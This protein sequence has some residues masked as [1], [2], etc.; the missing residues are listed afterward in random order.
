MG[1]AAAAGADGV[2][3]LSETASTLQDSNVVALGGEIFCGTSAAE[4]AGKFVE[5]ALGFGQKVPFVGPLFG[6]LTDLKELVDKD[7]EAG[8]EGVRLSLWCIGVLE[9][10]NKCK[11]LMGTK[12]KNGVQL[13]RAE[14]GVKALVEV[15]KGRE[16]ARSDMQNG[17]K[18]FFRG[19]K[20]FFTSDV[21]LSKARDAQRTV[22]EF[23]ETVLAEVT[24]D[25][26]AGVRDVRRDVGDLLKR[27]EKLLE[28]QRSL[29]DVKRTLDTIQTD[30]TAALHI[31]LNTDEVRWFTELLLQG[32]PV[33]FGRGLANQREKMLSLAGLMVT[34]YDREPE[35]KAQGNIRVRDVG[36]DAFR[37]GLCRNSRCIIWSSQGCCWVPDKNWSISDT[38][39]TFERLMQDKKLHVEVVVVCHKYG[40]EDTA[41]RLLAAGVPAVVWVNRSLMQ[42]STSAAHKLVFN[43]LH[44]TIQVI[45]DRRTNKA[46]AEGTLKDKM[47]GQWSR[48]KQGVLLSR[49]LPEVLEGEPGGVFNVTGFTAASNLTTT[50]PQREELE[51]AVCDLVCP[52]DL[53]ARIEK[54]EW[55]G[56]DRF[57]Y[58]RAEGAGSHSVN[59]CRAVAFEAC[60]TC[61]VNKE[62]EIC[63]RVQG[64]ADRQALDFHLKDRGETGNNLIWIDLMVD[65]DTA[66]LAAW[67]NTVVSS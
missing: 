19:A 30:V 22:K 56:S 50:K 31:L 54:S 12:S 45:L 17:V 16:K 37:E 36:S 33:V 46:S 48:L 55:S 43:V 5:K 51:L 2:V 58:I 49:E 1:R 40:A 7:G 63:W 35:L 21:F 20:E 64:I 53:L 23:L 9:C 27:S 3:S 60:M 26:A 6:V 10:V 66:A 4:L 38:F 15:V 47:T 42:L 25:M 13:K 34:K 41:K 62:C 61:L 28:M 32:D 14:D 11:D 57:F 44:P 59:R 52:K 65:S 18:A 24:V 39:D 8:E 29:K 67:L